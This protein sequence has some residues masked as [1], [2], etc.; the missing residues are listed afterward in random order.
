[1]ILPMLD[2]AVD[3]AMPVLARVEN[4]PLGRFSSEDTASVA[5]SI[6]RQVATSGMPP[7]LQPLFDELMQHAVAW[8]NE[9]GRRAGILVTDSSAPLAP[10][11]SS[12]PTPPPEAT[13]EATP[14]PSAGKE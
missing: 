1:M 4:D 11:V 6:S 7:E 10:H 8:V 3:D 12:S 2:S 14:A 13:P 5:A 9:D